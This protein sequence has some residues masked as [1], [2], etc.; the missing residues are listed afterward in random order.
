M[1]INASFY[2]LPTRETPAKWRDTTPKDFVFAAKASRYITHMK[3]LKDPEESTRRFFDAIEM[4]N[5]KLGPILFQLPPHWRVNVARL[6][7]FLKA[8]PSGH[9]YTFEFRDSSWFV[10]EV[11]E[12]LSKHGAA[13]CVYDLDGSTSP[14]EL[15]ADFAYLRLHGPDG[16]YRGR[17]DGRALYG[18][19]KRFK[20]WL[21]DRRDVYCFFD[22]DDSGYAA[23]DARRMGALARKHIGR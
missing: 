3:K 16:P 12:A 15:T 21:D 6:Q 1:E 17:Y 19:V 20:G 13:F 4:L 14:V 23:E 11:Y 7:E 9:R 5:P 8:L 18:W 2:R 10:P 22:N